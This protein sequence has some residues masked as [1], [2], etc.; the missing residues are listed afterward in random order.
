MPPGSA[1]LGRRG[2]MQRSTVVYV[3]FHKFRRGRGTLMSS[4]SSATAR[5]MPQLRKRKMEAMHVQVSMMF[6]S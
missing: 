2:R 6:G 1:P 3:E 4:R 5:A